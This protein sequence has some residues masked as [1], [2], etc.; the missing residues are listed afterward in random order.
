MELFVSPER[1][2][3]SLGNRPDDSDRHADC[4]PVLSLC[5]AQITEALD[6]VGAV[7]TTHFSGI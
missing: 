6:H 3:W 5:C 4:S 7:L 2:P 1:T